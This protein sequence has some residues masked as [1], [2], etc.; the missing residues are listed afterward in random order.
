MNELIALIDDYLFQV[1][2]VASIF[3]EEFGVEIHEIL[4][5]RKQKIPFKG[6]IKHRNIF[7]YTFHGFGLCANYNK[8]EVDFDFYFNEDKCMIGGFDS[9]RLRSFAKNNK[10]K[11]SQ[12]LN[13]NN[14]KEGLEQLK[15]LGLIIKP[16]KDKH[17]GLWILNNNLEV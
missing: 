4:W 10:I 12:F 15:N 14:I 2:E 17:T 1:K 11:Y 16:P 8:K 5:E 7:H 9:W 3:S 6:A 13:E